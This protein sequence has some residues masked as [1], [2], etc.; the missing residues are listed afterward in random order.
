MTTITTLTHHYCFSEPCGCL[1]LPRTTPPG[2][3]PGMPSPMEPKRKRCR[4]RAG[5]GF[6]WALG[7]L[8]GLSLDFARGSEVR[9]LCNEQYAALVVQVV[10]FSSSM[11]ARQMPVVHIDNASFRTTRTS[12]SLVRPTAHSF[13]CVVTSSISTRSQIPGVGGSVYSPCLST[14]TSL[15]RGRRT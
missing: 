9:A 14:P 1:M 11:Q 7:S 6:C 8:W 2:S 10:L 4:P 5:D 15:K 12:T 3:K 13:Q